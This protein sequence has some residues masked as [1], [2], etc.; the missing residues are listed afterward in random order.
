MCSAIENVEHRGGQDAGVYAAEVTVERQLQGLGHGAAGGHGDSE[1]GV[2]AQLGL[3]RRA[4][5]GN[6][7]LVDQALVGGVHALQFGSN[8]G[9]NVFDG[10]QYALAPEVGFVAV[11]QFHGLMLACGCARRHDGAAQ[12]PAFQ[13]YV[14]LNGRIA[15]RVQDFAG[16][17]G[18]NLSHM[19][20]H[21]AMH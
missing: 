7:G 5:Q 12:S 9:F 16:A 17:N 8:H 21:N 6:H 13:N 20:P 3:V 4:V 15:A 11:A 19:I 10:L 2:G 1:N 14:R 18:N